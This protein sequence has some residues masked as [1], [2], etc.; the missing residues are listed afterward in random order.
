MKTLKVAILFFLIFLS[1]PVL[2]FSGENRAG[3]VMVIT[4]QGVINP[5][6]SE[7]I[8]KSIEE[9]N[10]EGMEALVIEL[11]TPG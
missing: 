2:L 9:A 11:D 8:A 10:E 3:Q 6:S 7:Y 5:V 1:L 4:V